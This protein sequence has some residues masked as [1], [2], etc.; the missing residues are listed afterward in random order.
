MEQRA[1]WSCWSSGFT[2]QPRY[3]FSGRSTPMCT[4]RPARERTRL[5]ESKHINQTVRL[6]NVTLRPPYL[7]LRLLTIGLLVLCCR[8]QTA[9]P[10]GRR[11]VDIQYAPANLLHP[12]DLERVQ[13]L[14]KGAVLRAED[15]G[16]A[17]DRLF[18]TGRFDDIV[19][20]T[21][22]SG[23]GVIVRFSTQA[24]RFISGVSVIGSNPQPPNRG[25][26]VSISQLQ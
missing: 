12:A 16:E 5:H 24:A 19:A 4:S 20:E 9:T 21:E 23:E 14:K 1:R 13:V 18:A 10:I 3:S 2:T 26:L 22:E 6:T 15:L 17:I 7:I 8:A 11:I 25:E